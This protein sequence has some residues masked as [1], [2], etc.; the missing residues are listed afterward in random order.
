[1][2]WMRWK[3]TFKRWNFFSALKRWKEIF[4]RYKQDAVKKKF[5]ANTRMRWKKIFHRYQQNAVKKNFSPLKSQILQKCTALISTLILYSQEISLTY[6]T[7]GAV[8]YEVGHTHE[9][10]VRTL[11]RQFL[12]C[13]NSGECGEKKFFTAEFNAILTKI[14]RFQRIQR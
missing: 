9:V 2:R 13:K 14:H 1:M 5:T 3:K 6:V 8:D 12:F 7:D 11:V 4:H 10:E